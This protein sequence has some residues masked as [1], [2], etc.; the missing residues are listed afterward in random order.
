M[1]VEL[2]LYLPVP[3][4]VV[5]SLCLIRPA[6][7]SVCLFSFVQDRS[8][9]Q[10]I[11]HK[12][13]Q[14]ITAKASKTRHHHGGRAHHSNVRPAQRERHGSQH[15]EE[16]QRHKLST[17][18]RGARCRHRFKRHRRYCSLTLI[19]RAATD[20]LYRAALRNR[21]RSRQRLGPVRYKKPPSRNPHHH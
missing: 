18:K 3:H 15:I 14:R 5:C 6:F 17:E 1:Q 4:I 19:H 7:T 9:C 16:Q 11:L 12:S 10:T 8:E 20:E 2:F 13:R 21:H